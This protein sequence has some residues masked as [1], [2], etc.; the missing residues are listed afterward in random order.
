LDISTLTRL[1]YLGAISVSRLPFFFLGN[2]VFPFLKC[3]YLDFF[4]FGD[5]ASHMYIYL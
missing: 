1:G 4:S 5:E 3:I 2:L